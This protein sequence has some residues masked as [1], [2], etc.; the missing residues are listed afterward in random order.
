MFHPHKSS[1]ESLDPDVTLPRWCEQFCADRSRLKSFAIK[2]EVAGL[3]ETYLKLE[4][5]RLARGLGYKGTVEVG[6]ESP[7]SK[8]KF[9]NGAREN[10]WRLKGWVKI[11]LG[12]SFLWTVAAPY[13]SLR[14]KKFGTYFVEW[15]FTRPEDETWLHSNPKR[16]LEYWAPAIRRVVAGKRFRGF[17]TSADRDRA[18]LAERAASG[19]QEQG[20]FDPTH[21]AL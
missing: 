3:D 6:I 9:Y 17:L 5:M 8:V 15:P 7:G 2:R 14:T 1:K 10:R 19:V 13:L 11:L 4:I 18:V 12:I 21:T 16:F 20:W